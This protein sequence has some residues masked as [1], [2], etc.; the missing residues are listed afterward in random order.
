MRILTLRASCTCSRR[1]SSSSVNEPGDA[2]SSRRTES[3]RANPNSR[4]ELPKPFLS[5]ALAK[6][7]VRGC[8]HPCAPESKA[9]HGWRCAGGTKGEGTRLTLN[10]SRSGMTK[11]ATRFAHVISRPT[12]QRCDA[13]CCPIR[14]REG[15]ASTAQPPW[16]P[17][18]S[19]RD[20][21]Y[22]EALRRAPVDPASL[23]PVLP[24]PFLRLACHGPRRRC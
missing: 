14:G 23:G 10:S 9:A 3:R 11:A 5:R 15:L 2:S 12:R 21:A 22:P 1:G 16:S 17:R 7:W 24:G 13:T 19:V 4:S 8:R 6:K 20:L 18:N